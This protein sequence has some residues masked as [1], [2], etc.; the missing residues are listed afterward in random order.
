MAGRG[1]VA[2]MPAKVPA[3]IETTLG[4]LVDAEP[5]LHRIA[6][7]EVT[8]AKVRYHLA[9][10]V[11]QVG[12]ATKAWH[13]ARADLFQ[14]L[15]IERDS[16]TPEER[17]MGPTVRQ[18]TPGSMPEFRRQLEE[19][20]A[21]AVTVAWG[22]VRSEDLPHATAAELVALGPLCELVEPKE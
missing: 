15:G 8:S 16:R 22:P 1:N 2:Q 4:V 10:L 20:N 11:Q 14:T 18:I 21:T 19:L 12:D 17:A 5:T 6:R 7:Q 9:R 3:S 13:V